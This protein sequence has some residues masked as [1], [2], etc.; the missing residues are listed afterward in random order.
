M[1][2]DTLLAEYRAGSRTPADVVGD[3][4]AAIA[5]YPDPAVWIS[6]V[7][8]DALLA[9]AAALQSDPAALKLPLYG[10][11]FSVKDNIDALGLP[12]TA[13]CPAF[14]YEPVANAVVVQKLLDAGAMLIGKTNLDQFATGL[15]GVRSPHGAPRC[16]FDELYISGGSSSG[17]AVSVG[18]GLVA[19]ALG[20]DTAGSGRVPAGFNNIVGLKPTKGLVSG[21]GMVP[22]CRSLDCVSI[23]GQTAADALAVLRVLE[24]LDETDPYSRAAVPCELE[25]ETFRFGVLEEQDRVF[26]GDSEAATLYDAAIENAR[27]L[28]GTPVVIDFTP[29]R[30][31]AA[32]LYDG[33]FVAERLAAIEPFFEAQAGSMDPVVRG[34][35]AGAKGKSAADAF[36]GIYRLGALA[37]DAARVWQ[38]IDV[39]LV[40]TSPTIFRVSEVMAD[41]IRLNSLL[42]TYTNFVNLLDYAAIAVPAG[43]RAN[44]LPVGVTLI[45]PAFSDHDLA[46]LGSRLHAAAACGHGLSRDAAVAAI[47]MPSRD[48]LSVDLVVAGAHLSGMALNYQLL[49]VGAEFAE[50]VITAPDYKLMALRGTTPPKPGLVRAPG[51]AGPGIEIEVWRMDEAA[52]GRFVA[53]LPAPMGIGKVVLADGRVMPGFLCEACALEDAEDITHH[54]GWRAYL[55]SLGR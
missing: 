35:V 15:V 36:R 42:G 6:L 19:F 31:V 11:P 12:T 9:R 34:I 16:V 22:A 3:V 55:Q 26:S 14:G 54:G 46:V 21:T 39:M 8:P 4:L 28:G 49:E 37:R 13:A 17:A 43:F 20:T 45:G 30:D 32:L 1:K 52:F 5:A 50:T 48:V 24:G 7:P 40:P 38:G 23:F 47:E 53:S 51:F 25:L 2:I 18:A 44:G 41:P 27:R 33:P 10:I 29:F